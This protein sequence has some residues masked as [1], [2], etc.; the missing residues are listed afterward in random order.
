MK[1]S[2]NKDNKEAHNSD[3][4]SKNLSI[5]IDEDKIEETL[6]SGVRT[7]IFVMFILA[8]AFLNMTSYKN[9]RWLD[10]LFIKD[11]HLLD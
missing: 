8:N 1:E 11:C 3:I 9:K 6:L 4:K 7:W 10:L 2:N 5:Y